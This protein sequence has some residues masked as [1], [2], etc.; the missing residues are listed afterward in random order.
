[1]M[2]KR[3]ALHL[4]TLTRSHHIPFAALG[5]LDLLELYLFSHLLAFGLVQPCL[6]PDNA[7]ALYARPF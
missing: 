1:M 5:P 6:A 3:N 2:R 7:R 4:G